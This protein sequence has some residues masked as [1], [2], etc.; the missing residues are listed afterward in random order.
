MR[1]RAMM[2][3]SAGKAAVQ[4]GEIIR[5]MTQLRRPQILG[6]VGISAQSSCC[7]GRGD[8]R[9]AGRHA[10]AW[11]QLPEASAHKVH[12]AHIAVVIAQDLGHPRRLDFGASLRAA[13]AA[14][15]RADR[16]SSPAAPAGT[17]AA[18]PTQASAHRLAV[19]PQPGDDLALRDPIRRHRLTCADSNALGTPRAPS[20]LDR[21]NRSS[22][23]AQT[24]VA[25]RARWCTC[26][27][28]PVRS[29]GA[30]H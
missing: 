13:S 6:L 14:P 18:R 20:C 27:P 15:A 9:C 16:A 23:R 12:R 8:S 22:V 19:D 24:V 7:T 17:A 30:R 21:P 29:L 26:C 10:L 1:H 2:P 11:A 25:G 3:T 5:R 28:I 4:R